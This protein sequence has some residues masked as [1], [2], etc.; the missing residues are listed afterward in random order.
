MSHHYAARHFFLVTLL[1]STLLR[2]ALAQA[3]TPA[4]AGKIA[5]VRGSVLI[6]DS[7]AKVVADTE[8]KRDRKIGPG[9]EFYV[10]ETIQTRQDGRVKLEFLEGKNEVVLGTN[11]SLNISKAGNGLADASKGTS[12][13]LARGEIRSNV[14]TKYS[15]QGSNVFEVRTP[16]AVAGVRGTNFFT[17]FKPSTGLT[18]VA[19]VTGAVEF[20]NL[21]NPGAMVRLSPG[22]FAQLA[23]SAT[24]PT[25]PAPLS[26]NPELKSSVD[27]LSASRVEEPVSSSSMDSGS[28]GGESPGNSL[29]SSPE[30][31]S[32]SPVA[33][34]A[35]SSS[36]DNASSDSAPLSREP[37]AASN[38]SSSDGG[39]SPAST[40]A[41]GSA[42]S[43]AL[44]G[45]GNASS[46][47]QAAPSPRF[48]PPVSQAT[49]QAQ[50]N[51]RRIREI[52]QQ[53]QQNLNAPG[54]VKIKL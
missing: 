41:A 11:T 31:N 21:N 22:T 44:M 34:Q 52:Q 5:L 6:L 12:L 54:R 37:V 42:P 39:R 7:N 18:Q 28:A 29:S 51:L 9:T 13:N 2:P 17:Q 38:A 27:Q 45:E 30:Q 14:K 43:P 50:D 33:Q 48:V 36:P 3:A 1:L 46:R 47:S 49:D 19:L 8:G 40:A 4:P 24:A 20:K 25:P 53:Q 16:N 10:G 32:N 26:A 23:G 15:G 35:T